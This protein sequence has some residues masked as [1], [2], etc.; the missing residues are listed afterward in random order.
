[1]IR[2]GRWSRLWLA[3]VSLGA[4]CMGGSEESDALPGTVEQATTNGRIVITHTPDVGPIEHT[5]DIKPPTAPESLT[6]AAAQEIFSLGFDMLRIPIRATEHTGPGTINPGAYADVIAA[7]NRARAVKPDITIFASLRLENEGPS[8]PG[9]VKQGNCQSGGYLD[10]QQYS[11]L[12]M[13]YALHFKNANIRVDFLGPDNENQNLEC[14]ITASKFASIIDNLKTRYQ[15]N[16]MAFP[17]VVGNCAIGPNGATVGGIAFLNDLNNQGK[18]DRLNRASFHGGKMRDASY[19]TGMA[20][21]NTAARGKQKW[22]SEF[23]WDNSEL[24]GFPGDKF[25]LYTLFDDF[26]KAGMKRIVWWYFRPMGQEPA[27]A[28]AHIQTRFVQHTNN[29]YTLPTDDED[30][31]AIEKYKF[32]S[33]AFKQGNDVTLI[34]INDTGTARNGKWVEIKGRTFDHTVTYR[35]WTNSDVAGVAGSVTHYPAGCP[36]CFAVDLPAY[37][38]TMVRVPN[39]R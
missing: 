36:N 32:N 28:Q 1:M 39:V 16:T 13:D 19:L 34:V 25:A 14:E 8:F 26:D 11:R 35:R 21:W 10:A 22:D 9:W 27:N 2:S 23:H 6:A 33:R 17:E 3:A 12:L 24:T 18:F 7:V 5:F 38:I 20:A 15:N 29:A 37:S 30:G 4:G 31:V